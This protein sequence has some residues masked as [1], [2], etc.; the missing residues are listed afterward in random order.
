MAQKSL[1]RKSRVATPKPAQ[2]FFSKKGQNGFFQAVAQSEQAA[3]QAKLSIGKPGDPYEREA[4]AVADQVVQGSNP[5]AASTSSQELQAKPLWSRITPLLQRSLQEPAREELI[6][7]QAEEEEVVQPQAEEEQEK[8]LQRQVEEEEEEVIQPQSEEEEEVVQPQAEEEQEKML[9]RQV[10]EEEEEVIQPQ[11][12]EEE[13]VQ[14]AA[15]RTSVLQRQARGNASLPPNYNFGQQLRSSKGGGSPL[16]EGI[17]NQMERGFGTDF[18]EV[19]IH[20]GS[21]A[22]QMSQS[23]HAKAF[24]HGKDI[25]FNQNTFDPSSKTG[26]HLIAHELTHTIQQGAVVRRAPAPAPVA[27]KP[28]QAPAIQR[29]P[30]GDVIDEYTHYIPGF[31][32]FT[33]LVGYN[34]VTEQAVQRT[35]TN[36]VRGLLELI[37]V[38]GVMIFRELQERGIL[39]AAFTW[40]SNE[41]DRL[42]LTRAS[43]ERLLTRAID[44]FRDNPLE[45]LSPR[46]YLERIF[47]GLL[48]RVIRFAA[49]LRDHLIQMIKNALVAVLRAMAIDRMPAY[50]LLTKILRHDPITGE[51]VHATTVEILEDFLRMIGK[52]QELAQM[53]QRGTLERTANW[54]DANIGRFMRLLG[55]LRGIFHRVWDAFSVESLRDPIGV[56]AGIINEFTSFVGE[57][58]DFAT[59]V[60]RTVLQFIKDALLGLLREH[61]SGIRGYRLMTVI[62]GRDP[63]TDE[64]VPRT[65]V[66]VIGGFVQLVAGEETFQQMR[67]TGAIERMV[68][69]VDNLIARL[70]ITWQMIRDLFLG[71]WNDLGIEDLIRP[72][73]AFQRVMHRFGDPIRRL[74]T[75]IVVVIRK[76]I[77][78]ILELM[79]F[80]TDLIRQIIQ[81]AM[82]AF[83]QIKR[84]PVQ[85][86]INLLRAIKLGF[87][88]FFGNI[89]R[90]LLAGLTGWLFRELREA[91]VNPPQDFSFRSILGF[92]LEV[93]GITVERIWEKLAQHPAIGPERVARLRAM[94]GRLTGAWAFIQEVMTEGPGAIW[95]HIQERLSNLWDTVLETIRN[96]V[97]TRIINQM[98]T[99]LLSMLDPTGIMA[100][101]NSVIALYRAIQSFIE[102]LREILQVINS[103]VGGILQIAR[104][105]LATAAN[106]LE[107]AMSRAMPVV[108][109]FLAN[110]V[111]LRGLGRRIGEMIGRVR[112]L[113]DRALTWLVNRAVQLGAAALRGLR[114]MAS[115][116]AGAVR[117]WL[118]LE[119]RFQA[120]NGEHHRLYFSG[121]ESNAVLMM[122]SG[123]PGPYASWINNLTIANTSSSAGQQ[124]LQ[125]KNR[126]VAK[127][128]EID[129]TKN[130]RVTSSFTDEQKQALLRTKLDELS[131]LTGPLFTGTRPESASEENGRITFGGLHNGLYGT[132]M[133][134]D[135]LSN[136]R[137]PRGSE[138]SLSNP[139]SYQVIN[140]RR[141]QNGSYY[142]RGHL[143]NH[144]IGGTGREWKNLT[145]LTR[146][147]NS[148]HDRRVETPVYNSVIAGNIVKY[149]V[150]AQYNRSSST[151]GLEN[152]VDRATIQEDPETVKEIIRAEVHVPTALSCEAK[153]VNP[154]DNSETPL[155]NATI[156]N[157]INQS[158]G[159]YD[160]TGGARPMVYLSEASVSDFQNLGLRIDSRFANK[161]YSAFQ[162]YDFRSYASLVEHQVNGRDYFTAIQQ[163]V[164]RQLSG[165]SYVRLYR[166]S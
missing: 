22:A 116:V 28:A 27:P 9:Q 46:E 59:D 69:W 14:R 79:N 113:V 93:L 7:Q 16:P 40:V 128:R 152:A 99:R 145:P 143:L 84:N 100:V 121:N 166:G 61:A 138:P 85:F 50:Q 112:G 37:P 119:K 164:L 120:T 18:S 73:E 76:V 3:L 56:L 51:E 57:V 34:P 153:L 25:Y 154:Q 160:L 148:D 95:R 63:V 70:G 52:T 67:Q 136:N 1:Q 77:E 12:E 15:V 62:L 127:A 118:G 150:T 122:A 26:Q 81:R 126:A 165:L 96:W 20:T 24:T 87:Q 17:A 104:G 117:R 65:A 30:F 41:L 125:R 149:R 74:L 144:L 89:G 106:F 163:G 159:A 48:N 147:A 157:D 137:L 10:E 31:S 105:S 92:V 32:L 78:V 86:L 139:S 162:E 97:V 8:M 155:V 21:Q 131:D 38:F 111:G 68:G 135:G 75:F 6:Q 110:Q 141:N 23:I 36:L 33:V 66:N 161:L 2:P 108:I 114:S 5:I 42:E 151:G 123:N 47:L 72:I 90:H 45:L 82:A 94:L 140:Q 124:R 53:R 102:R 146:D 109:G 132:R 115:Q 129:Q 35:P 29:I 134:A 142:I 44:H 71:L 130:R 91:G 49:S 11:S 98:V 156:Q 4:D 60:A 55:Q 158:P 13:E 101:V 43:F 107:N 103:F 58:F 54:L 64:R 19:R 39:Q 83:N 133:V 88:Q 80:P